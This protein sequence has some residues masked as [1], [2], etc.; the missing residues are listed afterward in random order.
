MSWKEI[1][2]EREEERRRDVERAAR[3]RSCQHEFA[4][5]QGSRGGIYY[6]GMI[7]CP[8]C[9]ATTIDPKLLHRVP[10]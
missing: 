1:E 8:K 10:S 5:W 7:R 6:I 4:P 3:I 9:D 2:E